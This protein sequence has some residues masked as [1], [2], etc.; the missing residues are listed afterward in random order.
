MHGWWIYLWMTCVVVHVAVCNP[1]QCYLWLFFFEGMQTA[2]VTR[3]VY[4]KIPRIFRTSSPTE[5]YPNR[6]CDL[7]Q[8]A[9]IKSSWW[10]YFLEKKGTLLKLASGNSISW[11]SSQILCTFD[12]AA[13]W[14]SV[15]AV[16][17]YIY[18]YSMGSD[19]S[20]ITPIRPIIKQQ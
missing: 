1:I 16:A 7:R 3:C 15:D 10:W 4:L 6:W 2:L 11:S 13:S 5:K 17:N 12:S 18:M 14:T 20:L 8:V 9:G 19:W